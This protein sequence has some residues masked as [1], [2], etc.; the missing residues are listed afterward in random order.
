[1][2][3]QKLDECYIVDAIAATVAFF[4]FPNI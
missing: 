3:L 2:S 1:M 4:Q